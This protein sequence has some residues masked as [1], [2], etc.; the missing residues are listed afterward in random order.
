METENK[1]EGM[2][3][4]MGAFLFTTASLS[5]IALMLM[6]FFITF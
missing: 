4:Y 2:F 5:M 1:K 6:L 3:L